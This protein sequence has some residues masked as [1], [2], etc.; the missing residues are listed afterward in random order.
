MK[1]AVSLP[2]LSLP[3]VTLIWLLEGQLQCLVYVPHCL[4]ASLQ[5]HAILPPQN[6][7]AAYV[8]VQQLCNH[9]MFQ[10]QY[11]LG[12]SACSSANMP[13]SCSSRPAQ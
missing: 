8:W 1:D 10:Q 13:S 5:C 2:L 3:A 4:C 11:T 9:I 7:L 6:T 12:M